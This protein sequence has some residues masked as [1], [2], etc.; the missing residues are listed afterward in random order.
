MNNRFEGDTKQESRVTYSDRVPSDPSAA[1]LP[2]SLPSIPRAL[3]AEETLGNK[4]ADVSEKRFVAV[5]QS[6]AENHGKTWLSPGLFA[7]PWNHVK[8]KRRYSK[9]DGYPRIP[10]GWRTPMDADDYMLKP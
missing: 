1:A 6:S 8:R 5:K 2:F 4:A 10:R 3:P 9:V 7:G